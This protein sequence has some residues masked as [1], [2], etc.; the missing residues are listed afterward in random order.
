MSRK[1][2]VP[3]NVLAVGTE[4]VGKYVGDLYFNSIDKNLYAFD[5]T[6]WVTVSG[7]G[8]TSSDTG[9]DGGSPNSIYSTY[10]GGAYDAVNYDGTLDGGTV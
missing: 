4:P 3:I 5:G 10:D 9:A 6:V 1:A 7:G 2:L 8:G